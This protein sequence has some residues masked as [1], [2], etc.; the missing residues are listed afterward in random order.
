ME[1]ET[2]R[3]QNNKTVTLQD[4]AAR[5]GV[6]KATVSLALRNDPRVNTD[7][8]A[9]VLTAAAELGYSPAQH[10]AARRLALKKQGRHVVNNL[11]A[12]C[13]PELF[14]HY[15]YFL[16][17][18]HGLLDVFTPEQYGLLTTHLFDQ[19]PDIAIDR[20]P[21]IFLRGELDGIIF[22]APHS[23]LNPMFHQLR[24]HAGFGDRPVV[25][26]VYPATF[27]SSVTIDEV[28]GACDSVEYLLALGHRH[29]MHLNY[30]LAA[31]ECLHPVNRLQAVQQTL[32]RNGLDPARHLHCFTIDFHWTMPTGIH[33]RSL[34][35]RDPLANDAE[36]GKQL[37]A[38]LRTHPEVTAIMAINDHSALKAWQYL[39]QAGFRVPED[40]SIIGFDDTDSMQGEDGRNLLT[41]VHLPLMEVGREAARHI[42][43][44]VTGISQHNEQ[45]TLPAF[46]VVREST[47]PA[48]QR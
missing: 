9:R 16:A 17:M 45:L 13:F 1:K 44:R 19:D 28:D 24:N 10:I 7:T 25:S 38:Y 46:L 23:M 34:S 22:Y 35:E 12:L 48:K 2:G 21:P 43:R 40:I 37:V 31:D 41:S 6:T 30:P 39:K 8:A 27:C 32:L 3:Q 47:G 29:I 14:G 36:V 18:Y 33:A 26:L 20:L 11:I 5:C 4:I 15:N 42:I